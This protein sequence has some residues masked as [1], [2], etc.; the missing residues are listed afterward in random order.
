MIDDYWGNM[1]WV[2]MF[3]IARYQLMVRFTKMGG[4][5]LIYQAASKPFGS[6]AALRAWRVIS[7]DRAERHIEGLRWGMSS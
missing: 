7:A 1:R 6:A 5:P 3:D 4:A 2:E